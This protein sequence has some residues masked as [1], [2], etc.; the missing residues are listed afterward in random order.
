[1][2]GILYYN[3]RFDTSNDANVYYNFQLLNFE[4]IKINDKIKAI[5]YFPFSTSEYAFYLISIFILIFSLITI[6]LLVINDPEFIKSFFKDIDIYFQ[7]TL[8]SL[9]IRYIIG[10]AIKFTRTIIFI[11]LLF[12][13][14][15]LLCILFVFL[16]TK[17]HKYK[18]IKYLITHSF[19]PSLFMALE[20]YCFLYCFC[21]YYCECRASNNNNN[22]KYKTEIVCN[23]L[24]F[25]IGVMVLTFKKDIIFPLVI[26]VFET[27]LLTRG[28]D[29]NFFVIL[30]DV[31][32]LLFTFGSVILAI[33]QKKKKI[34]ELED[35]FLENDSTE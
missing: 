11:N 12:S 15:S 20:T 9:S 35:D 13:S 34:F 5:S 32:I 16:N 22:Y 25:I 29:G 6:Y 31:F 18:N 33:F 21:F 3:F 24:F 8:L 26:V 10:M 27:G 19:L 17:T 14:I 30:C 28:N 1:M 2:I 23:I 7:I 4:F